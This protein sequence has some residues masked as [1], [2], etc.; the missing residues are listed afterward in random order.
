MMVLLA[1]M[2]EDDDIELTEAEHHAIVGIGNAPT[3]SAPVPIKEPS[4]SSRLLEHGYVTIND[5]G[6]LSLTLKGKAVYR[7]GVVA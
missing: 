1:G 6:C 4:V 3:M 7:R 2:A 5:S